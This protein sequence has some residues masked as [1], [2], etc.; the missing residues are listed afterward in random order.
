MIPYPF[1]DDIVAVVVV[2][3]TDTLT[4][5]KAPTA[6]GGLSVNK[7]QNYKYKHGIIQEKPL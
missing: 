1:A 7:T 4:A 6:R 2:I 3:T 5:S